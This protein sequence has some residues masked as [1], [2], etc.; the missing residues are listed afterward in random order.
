MRPQL[1]DLT[2]DPHETTNL[3]S[4]NPDVVARLAA[5]IAGWY[6]VEVREVITLW[7]E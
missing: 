3:A 6:P 2:A 4:E 7:E 5:E 1:F